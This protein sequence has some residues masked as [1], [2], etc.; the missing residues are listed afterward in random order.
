M[1]RLRAALLLV[2]A[3]IFPAAGNAAATVDEAVL[4]R[5]LAEP[6][7]V[8]LMRHAT[9]PG[10]G[11]PPGFVLDDCATQRNLSEGGRAQ[12]VRIGERLRAAGAAAVRV[13]SSRWCR[14]LDTARL[15]GLGPVEPLPALD[16]F[17]GRPEE[18]DARMA[19][20]R[21]WLAA[22]GLETPP[23]LVTHQVLVTAL[24]GVY[25]ASGEVVILRR[26]AAGG[27]AVVGS[28]ETE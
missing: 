3:F 9:A 27:L 11:D 1:T 10:T 13:F 14:S 26:D 5:V 16:S 4:R 2:F 19:A 8:F 15:L 20:I 12:A 7:H 23:V 24:T 18:R 21:A 6:G 28:F 25:P 17:F 22:D